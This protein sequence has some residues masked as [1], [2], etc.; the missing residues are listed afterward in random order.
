MPRD[1]IAYLFS[2]VCSIIFTRNCEKTAIGQ[3]VIMLLAVNQR[4]AT[5]I[6]IHDFFGIVAATNNAENKLLF[7]VASV[8]EALH[9]HRLRR[10]HNGHM[11]VFGNFLQY[12]NRNIRIYNYLFVSCY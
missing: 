4:K 12:I 8:K 10:E 9:A 2:C 7:G 6:I 1:F 11:I 3:F 5:F